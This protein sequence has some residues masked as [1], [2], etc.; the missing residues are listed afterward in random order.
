MG[1]QKDQTECEETNTQGE[2]T[3][4]QE[5]P[6]LRENVGP[7]A[8]QPS[9]GNTQKDGSQNLRRLRYVHTLVCG[10]GLMSCDLLP[11][12]VDR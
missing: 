2:R 3:A 1:F 7:E 12:V 5:A 11:E 6:R 10:V 4:K 9:S 8:E